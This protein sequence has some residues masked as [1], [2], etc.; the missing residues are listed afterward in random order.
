MHRFA[1]LLSV[2]A[3]NAIKQSFQGPVA[4]LPVK[5]Y[6][7]KISS[8]V[9]PF[10]P[11]TCR[12]LSFRPQDNSPKKVREPSS[13]RSWMAQ[14]P[15]SSSTRMTSALP[16]WM[17]LP[18]PLSTSSSFP[19]GESPWSRRRRRQTG[20]LNI[21]CL[22]EILYFCVTTFSEILGHLLLTAKNVAKAQG[23]ENGYRWGFKKV[24]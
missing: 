17:W 21:L 11:Y 19:G 15:L 7:E 5:V 12:C 18:R 13:T 6:L 9:R 23:L 2:G 20:K 10:S 8:H 24:F 4:R 1:R 22:F 16:L 3:S 14:S